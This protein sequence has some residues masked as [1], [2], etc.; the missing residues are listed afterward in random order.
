MRIL[1]VLVNYGTEQLNFLQQVI[2]ELK[3][4]KKYNVK[5][6][7]HSNILQDNVENIDLV[8]IIKLEN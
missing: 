5:V 8:N 6:V 3:A 1:A 7:V 2:N 4:F